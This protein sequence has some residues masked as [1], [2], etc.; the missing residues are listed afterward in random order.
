[1][2]EQTG[3]CTLI[4]ISIGWQF[5][6]IGKRERVWN[7]ISP[8]NAFETDRSNVSYTSLITLKNKK[9]IQAIRGVKL[10]LKLKLICKVLG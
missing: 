3:I 2:I 1:M 4:F 7:G 8:L 6:D 9:W 10:K 5:E